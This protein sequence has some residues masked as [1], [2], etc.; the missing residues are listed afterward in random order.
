MLSMETSAK[1]FKERIYFWMT[2]GNDGG[3]PF[4][5]SFSLCAIILLMIAYLTISAHVNL[6]RFT[7]AAQFHLFAP[8]C[9]HS[10]S[11]SS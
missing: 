11:V 8:Q 6:L 3:S 4:S 9:G 2:G 10:S 5:S 7:F 1:L